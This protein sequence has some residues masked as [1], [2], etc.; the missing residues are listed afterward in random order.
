MKRDR[1]VKKLHKLFFEARDLLKQ[2]TPDDLV[3]SDVAVEVDDLPET[4]AAFEILNDSVV[5]DGDEYRIELM[6]SYSLFNP[7][8]N[9]HLP[10]EE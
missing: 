10:P 3:R 7:A 5:H 4:F 6:W 2:L 8:A 1:Q 9:S